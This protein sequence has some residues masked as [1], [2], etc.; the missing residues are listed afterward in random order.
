M[1]PEQVQLLV[2]WNAS[3]TKANE[4]KAL[5]EAELD[6]RKKVFASF[7]PAPK[8]G[9]NSVDLATGGWI[10]RGNYKLS[11]KIDQPA[12]AATTEKLRELQVNVDAVVKWVPQLVTGQY[13]ELTKE[14]KDEFDKV[15]TI[16]PQTPTLELVPPKP[17]KGS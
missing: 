13:R 6:L 9:V 11:R 5:I 8:E 4:A 1:T 16:E 2:E 14:Q 3:V 10:L 17:K 12:L 7:Y 15:L